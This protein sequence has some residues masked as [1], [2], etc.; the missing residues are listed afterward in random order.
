MKNTSKCSELAFI[1]TP[2]I[3]RELGIYKIARALL[4]LAYLRSRGNVRDRE[5]VTNVSLLSHGEAEAP[6]APENV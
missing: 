5:R 4:R 1:Q 3:I 6:E 2:L